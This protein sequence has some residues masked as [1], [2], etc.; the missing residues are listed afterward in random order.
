MPRLLFK[1]GG[2]KD[3]LSTAKNKL[4]GNT[5]SLAKLCG[6]HERTVRDWL[7]EKY[8][9]SQSATGKISERLKIET[10]EIVKTL[11]D[12]WSISKAGKIGAVARYK[13]YD[14]PGTREGRS[15]GGTKSCFLQQ[16]ASIKGMSTGFVVRKSIHIP[17]N[18]T[19]LAEAIGIILGDGSIN[20]FQVSIS[21]SALVDREYADYIDIL[22]RR[23]FKIDVAR[24]RIRRN[25]IY[26]TL[27]S[28]NLVDYLNNMG[29]KI[30]DKIRNKLSIPKWIL[31]NE[32]CLKTCLRGLFDT[33]GCIYYH[34]H[35]TRGREYNDIGWSFRNVNTN[36]L[37]EFQ[38]FLLK[39][40]FKSKMKENGV[41]IYNRHDIH[42]YFD[43]IGSSNPK[44]ISKYS[45][46]FN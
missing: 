19:A 40:G 20:R 38:N 11:P 37:R 25:T 31:D 13:I 10:P 39:K 12:F 23:L 21:I 30:G 5:A 18:S 33:D 1:K 34:R 42:R 2:Q 45:N 44:H 26:L 36:L 41:W 3:F 27:S 6:V 9:I 43:E 17:Q 24:Q 22:F 14:N 28:R 29:L 16:K 35:F 8:L 7:R 32:N 15:K 4:R 46:Y